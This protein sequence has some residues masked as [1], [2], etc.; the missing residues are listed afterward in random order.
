MMNVGNDGERRYYVLS[1]GGY[2]KTIVLPERKKKKKQI[3]YTSVCAVGGNNDVCMHDVNL[4]ASPSH[5]DC[6]SLNTYNIIR[7]F[8]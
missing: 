7:I 4:C 3:L 8:Y 1:G 6:Q 2:N 5:N